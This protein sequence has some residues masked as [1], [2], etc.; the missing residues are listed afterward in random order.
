MGRVTPFPRSN[1]TTVPHHHTVLIVEDDV[2]V[3]MATADELRK[4]GFA[5]LEAFS[6]EE[7]VALL[8]A[9]APVS[10]L[11]TDVQLPGAMDG[12]ALAAVV[13]KT[14]PGLKIV[15]TSGDGNFETRAAVMADAFLP[16]PYLLEHV[17]SCI[18]SL[19][20]DHVA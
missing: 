13:A 1:Q 15:I 10:L 14:H 12:L 17:S 19:T 7:A 2:L 11:F 20:S 4:R 18:E 8:Q 3:R 16:K 6:A 9:R 5:V